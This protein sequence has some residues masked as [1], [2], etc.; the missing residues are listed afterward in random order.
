MSGARKT[1]ELGTNER[2]S[3]E[4][5]K[6]PLSEKIRQQ[7]L[8]LLLQ[9]E[10]MMFVCREEADLLLALHTCRNSPTPGGKFSTKSYCRML[11][12]G[13]E[14]DVLNGGGSGRRVS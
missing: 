5:V 2:R 10:E 1:P 12:E 8:L 3:I 13:K 6:V 7:L 11:A 14:Q 9:S 4:H